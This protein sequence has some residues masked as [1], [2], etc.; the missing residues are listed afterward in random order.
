MRLGST[1]DVALLPILLPTA[2]YLNWYKPTMQRP[3][4]QRVPDHRVQGTSGTEPGT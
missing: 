1:C 2:L 3:R 4:A